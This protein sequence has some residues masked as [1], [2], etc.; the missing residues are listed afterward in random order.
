MKKAE[1]YLQFGLV[2]VL[3]T[4]LLMNLISAQKVYQTSQSIKTDTVGGS[5]LAER[6]LMLGDWPE[7][8]NYL[9]PIEQHSRFLI[10]YSGLKND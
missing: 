8:D 7:A 4:L 10:D 2:T 5:S 9:H 6:Y 3:V 1:R